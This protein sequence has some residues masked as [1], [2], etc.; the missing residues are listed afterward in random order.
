MFKREEIEK[1]LLQAEQLDPKYE[2][3]GVQHHKYKLNPPI[4]KE[5]VHRIEERYNFQ[6]PEDYF[7]FITEAG[8][9]GAGPAY[10]IYQ[11]KNFLRKGSSPGVEKFYEAYRQSLARPFIV[12]PMKPGEVEYDYA[13]SKEAYEKNPEKY[14]VEIGNSDE[15]ALCDTNGY[16]V[17]GT[18]GCQWDFGLVISGER[19]G[20]VFDT[21]NEGGYSLAAGSF[22]EFYQE[23]LDYISDTKQFME[24]LEM[25]R[26][27]SNR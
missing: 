23:W 7:Q 14:F 21:D 5:F 6:L 2:M 3:F 16:L 13:F 27:I 19:R 12:Y 25:W 17:L 24:E 22:S 10:G 18:H 15:Y 8:D 4:R 1:V 11:F 20:Q 9:G 26:N